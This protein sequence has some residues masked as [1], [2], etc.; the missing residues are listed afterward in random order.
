M[1]RSFYPVSPIAIPASEAEYYHQ[2]SG[3]YFAIVQRNGEFFQ[4]RHQLD[5]T[6]ARVNVMEKRI[7]YVMGSGNHSRAYLHR[8]PGGALI[9]LPLAWYAEKGGYFAMNPGYDRPDHEG[10]RRPIAYD[11]MFC[12]NA[13]PRTP[14]ASAR[15]VY[16]GALPEGIDC[17]RCHG[18]GARHAQLASAAGSKTGEIRQAIVNP[19]R[20]AP[21]RQMEICMVC[22]LET[23]S[24][25]LPN[26]LP[27]YGRGPFSFR[28]GEPL[29]DFILNFDHAPETG[30]GDKFE[31]VNAAYRLRQSAC[32]LKSNP[33]LTCTTC[34]NPHDIPRGEA[35]QR[36]YTDICRQCHAALPAAHTPGPACADCHMPKR[37]AEDVI[38]VAVTDHLIQR[39][40][41]LNPLAELAERRETYRGP[42]SLYYPA[43]L[44]PSP[45][46]EL[47]LAVAQVKQGS[48][49]AAGIPLLAA[50]LGKLKP[51][52]PD[53][54]IELADA[55]EVKNEPGKS[56][57]AYREALRLAP[58]RADANRKLGA[59]LRRAGQPA[60]ALAPLN[61][62]LAA[63][64]TD[65]RAWH[66][67]GQAYQALNRPADA[68]SALR[69][70]IALD[71]DL[72]E[73]H[74]NLGA[75]HFTAGDPASAEPA[76]REAIRIQPNYADARY[77]LA[78]LLGQSA[79]FDQAQSELE[80]SLRSNP[81]F[82]D[83]H[84]LLADLLMAKNQTQTAAPHYR[85]ALKTNP[86]SPR[87]HLGLA[88]ALLAAGDI[89][90]A[91]PHLQQAA[92]GP[93]PALR[94]QAAD[95]LRQLQKTR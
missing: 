52:R 77:N 79:R 89:P 17:A 60:E 41:P 34:H 95:L 29:A 33:R 73:A 27:R 93:D 10:F 70:A 23:T 11:C 31:I 64:P 94:A 36:H 47:Y 84:L 63:D 14:A 7:D 1:G 78:M 8:T 71:P 72:P 85:E 44:P 20:L 38:H 83:A 37:R 6:G 22:H 68:G 42:V 16:T 92:A 90:A 67:L 69:K 58:T 12:H 76:F 54:Y 86:N 91:I 26:V 57:A 25:P 74:N 80:Q 61:R 48:N 62:S 50:L 39:R 53:W 40:P 18:P 2:P 21:D 59:A 9:E 81:A 3:S 82:T 35:A 66:E 49:L 51:Q 75:L 87:A 4:T 32:F 30:H 43:T 13:Y 28:P 5:P 65:P 55:Y 56:I 19:A 45:E 24:F 88:A 15:A 46:N